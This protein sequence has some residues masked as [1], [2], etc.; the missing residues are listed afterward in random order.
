MQPFAFA[1]GETSFVPGSLVRLPT[2]GGTPRLGIVAEVRATSP[3]V[4]VFP[5]DEHGQLLVG[6]DGAPRAAAY[7]LNELEPVQP[8]RREGRRDSAVGAVQWRDAAGNVGDGELRD[9]SL[10]G[11]GFLTESPPAVGVRIALEFGFSRGGPPILE[12][13]VRTV[14]HVHGGKQRVGCQFVRRVAPTDLA[15]LLP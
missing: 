8:N 9:V 4:W 6:P 11:L 14:V 1:A 12:C 15:S 13:Q 3:T 10:D 2:G 7:V 5:Y